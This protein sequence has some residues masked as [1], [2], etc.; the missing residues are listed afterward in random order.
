MASIFAMLLIAGC[1]SSPETKSE[2]VNAPTV[3]ESESSASATNKIQAISTISIPEESKNHPRIF[4]TNYYGNVQLD[5]PEQWQVKENPYTADLNVTGPDGVKIFAIQ[6]IEP[7]SGEFDSFDEM[8]ESFEVMRNYAKSPGGKSNWKNITTTT[9]DGHRMFYERE[10]D[11]N[12]VPWLSSKI[13]HRADLGIDVGLFEDD[14]R[15]SENDFIR[16]SKS[17]TFVDKVNLPDSIVWYNKGVALAG[18][19][20][21]EEAIQAFDKALELDL[22]DFDTWRAKVDALQA[23]GRY[24]DEEAT[25]KASENVPISPLYAHAP[26]MLSG[27]AIY[28]KLVYSLTTKLI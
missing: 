11:I 16:I 22:S 4:G 8:Q 14:L 3:S 13:D 26:K 21:H 6:F 20:K 17:F 24:E 5:I 12:G 18:E 7:I 27:E 10:S 25:L 1:V 15:I 23:L 2:R 28:R 9:N 19:K